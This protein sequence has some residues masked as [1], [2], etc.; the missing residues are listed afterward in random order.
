METQVNELEIQREIPTLSLA[1][2]TSQ[3]FPEDSSSLM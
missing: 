1:E 2:H 3:A